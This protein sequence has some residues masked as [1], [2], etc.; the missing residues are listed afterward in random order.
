MIPA[1]C[2]GFSDNQPITRAIVSLPVASHTGSHAQPVSEQKGG[3]AT[4]RS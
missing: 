2:S 1:I 3:S 4:T